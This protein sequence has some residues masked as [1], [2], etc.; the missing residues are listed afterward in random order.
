M[1]TSFFSLKREKTPISSGDNG[2]QVSY[3]FKITR[4]NL[5]FSGVSSSPEGC[6]VPLHSC[7]A[8][9]EKVVEVRL[10]HLKKFGFEVSPG[11]LYHQLG[12]LSEARVITGK[13]QGQ[14]TIY[15]MTEKGKDVFLE[16]KHSWKDVLQYVY[17]NLL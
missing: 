15:E 9:Q 17:D 4:K 10:L 1:T 11:T 12:M 8:F 2:E 16:F 13:K 5:G 3:F 6:E 14:K 7:R